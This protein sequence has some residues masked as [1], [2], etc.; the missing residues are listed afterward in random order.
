MAI[1]ALPGDGRPPT[2]RSRPVGGLQAGCRVLVGAVAHR[3]VRAPPIASSMWNEPATGMRPP[4]SQSVAGDLGNHE[5]WSFV[6]HDSPFY[7]AVE[8]R[9]EADGAVAAKK[10]FPRRGTSQASMPVGSRRKAWNPASHEKLAMT[11]WRPWPAT[12][13]APGMIVSMGQE[14]RGKTRTRHHAWQS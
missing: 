1:H 14:R 8:D 9:H 7:E 11:R 12:C 13:I 3:R 5:Q 10:A 4:V 6:A 2:G